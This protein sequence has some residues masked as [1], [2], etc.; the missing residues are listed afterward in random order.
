MTDDSSFN[1]VGAY[2]GYLNAWR[3]RRAPEGESLYAPVELNGIWTLMAK[4]V[5]TSGGGSSNAGHDVRSGW[6]YSQ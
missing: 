6:R 3:A 5:S 4:S 1:I 2:A